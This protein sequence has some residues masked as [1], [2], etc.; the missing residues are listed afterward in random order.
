MYIGWYESSFHLRY[1]VV[2]P[3][4]PAAD[5]GRRRRSK[6]HLMRPA[7]VGIRLDG[8]LRRRVAAHFGSVDQQRVKVKRGGKAVD[9]QAHIQ[10]WS[11]VD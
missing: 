2:E 1:D 4:R 6:D 9:L 3:L 8:D 10:K 7:A 5:G 11:I